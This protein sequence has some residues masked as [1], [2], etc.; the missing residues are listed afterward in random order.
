MADRV[1]RPVVLASAHCGSTSSDLFT[2]VLPPQV[3]YKHRKTIMNLG[4][5]EKEEAARDESGVPAA[6]A[7]K[8]GAP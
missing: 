5:I 1:R 8:V 7:G 6:D 2:K 4:W 3:F